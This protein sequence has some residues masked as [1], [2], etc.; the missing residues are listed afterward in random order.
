MQTQ[1]SKFKE[2]NLTINNLFPN[3]NYEDISN[4]DLNIFEE[5]YFV[6]HIP[7]SKKEL[8]K[9]VC[10]L[11]ESVG[12]TIKFDGFAYLVAAI[13]HAQDNFTYRLSLTND[14]YPYVST[15]YNVSQ[16][17]IDRSIRNAIK[18][19]KLTEIYDLDN[20]FILQLDL[21]KAL[22][23]KNPL[24]NKSFILNAAYYIYKTTM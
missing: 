20:C 7:D 16:K 21:D 12:I 3:I 2:N 9:K 15:V 22:R 13:T 14:I 18:S 4:Y 5:T 1:L 10:S 24:T 6:E 23:N 17:N 8:E 11:L 19:S